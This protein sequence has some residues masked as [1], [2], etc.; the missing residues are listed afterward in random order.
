MF[1]TPTNSI[2]VASLKGIKDAISDF[3]N[4]S[5]PDEA[6]NILNRIISLFEKEPLA[7][8]QIRHFEVGKQPLSLEQL[9]YLFHRFYSLIRFLLLSHTKKL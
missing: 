1:V 7:R 4:S 3:R 8:F 5:V 6:D 9:D 2:L